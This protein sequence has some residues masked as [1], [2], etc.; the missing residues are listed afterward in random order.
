MNLQQLWNGLNSRLASAYP[1]R[2][3]RAMSLLLLENMYGRTMTDLVIA[4]DLPIEID[5]QAL[6]SAVER[7]LEGYPI[8]Y[9]IGSVQFYGCKIEVNPSVLIPRPETEELVEW[10]LKEDAGTRKII[11]IG[12]GSG[13]I[14]I[15]LA[16]NSVCADTDVWA[17]DISESALAMAA[18][19]ARENGVKVNFLQA[20]ILKWQQNAQLQQLLEQKFDL[21]VSNP[22]YVCQC[23]KSLMERNVLDY[24]PHTALFVEDSDP[25]LFY[26]A[27]AKY[28]ELAL[29]QHGALYFEINR[30]FGRQTAQMLAD[31]GFDC[32][33]RK[34]MSDK[35]RMIRAWKR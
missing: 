18:G 15:A 24:E 3:A 9:L 16:R 25:L 26:V 1:E 21:I 14:A 34:D 28:A 22:P 13:C 17:V 27:I 31:H 33:L 5:Q 11:D 4:P 19:N 35:P 12:T 29:N 20:D 2:E 32:E 23:E 7:L 6:D 10:I 8:Q 30:E